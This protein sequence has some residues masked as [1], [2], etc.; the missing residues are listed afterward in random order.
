MEVPKIFTIVQELL[1]GGPHHLIPLFQK[2][3]RIRRL[4]LI[5]YH[6]NL[7]M[8]YSVVYTGIGDIG[9]YWKSF[10]GGIKNMISYKNS[11]I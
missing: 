4:R 7:H 5:V 3:Q 9:Y 8:W 1:C 2:D 6:H 10:L 11:H